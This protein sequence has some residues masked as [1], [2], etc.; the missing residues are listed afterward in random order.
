[1]TPHAP[2]MRREELHTI[3]QNH[4]GRARAMHASELTQALFGLNTATL[5]RR[6][7]E[8]IQELRLQG[9]PICGRPKEGYFLAENEAELVE[10][11]EYLHEH[12]S[13]TLKQIAAMRGVSLADLRGQLRLPITPAANGMH[14]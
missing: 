7:R 14:Q 4:V 9:V 2:T 5:Q 12:A 8:A 13:A 11:C 6:L 3:L 1:M 10:T